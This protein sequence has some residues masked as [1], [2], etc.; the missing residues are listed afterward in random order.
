MSGDQASERD[1]LFTPDSVPSIRRLLV[2]VKRVELFKEEIK[3]KSK[4]HVTVGNQTVMG[5][6]LAFFSKRVEEE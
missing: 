4:F 3:S 2:S 6:V 5:N 1:M